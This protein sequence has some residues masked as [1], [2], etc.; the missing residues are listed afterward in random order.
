LLAFILVVG[1]IASSPGGRQ[2]RAK[3]AAKRGGEL[4]AVYQPRELAGTGL[5]ELTIALSEPGRSYD[6]SEGNRRNILLLNKATGES[7]RI[8]PANDRRIGKM[9]YLSQNGQFQEGSEPSLSV[10]G[11]SEAEQTPEAYAYYV[12]EVYSNP[13]SDA[14]FDVLVGRL[15][16]GR[17]QTVMRG[18]GGVESVWMIGP[19]RMGLI[20][21]EKEGLHHRV[22]DLS[23]LKV[24]STR[25][26]EIG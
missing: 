20:V 15:A 13:K 22:I 8:L 7:R 21:R 23:T 5:I 26:I 12:L 14:A 9:T 11:G 19:Q 24:V 4:F 3:V 2:E 18:V 6:S 17:Q 1:M 10:A 16:D 25:Q